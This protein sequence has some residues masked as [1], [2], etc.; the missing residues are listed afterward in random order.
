MLDFPTIQIFATIAQI[1]SAIFIYLRF[2]E[3]KH[4]RA[5]RLFA[6][7][8]LFNMLGNA[9]LLTR[10][11]APDWVSIY[12][13]NLFVGAAMTYFLFSI[14]EFFQIKMTKWPWFVLLF[15]Q[16]LLIIYFNRF[17]FNTPVRII[18]VGI[19]AALT[20]IV[21]FIYFIQTDQFKGTTIR[22]ILLVQMIMVAFAFI[23][24][25]GVAWFYI[26]Q[27]QMSV[28]DL[29]G[30]DISRILLG[31][32]GFST[33]LST[34]FLFEARSRKR[35]ERTASELADALNER[36]KVYML[37]SHELQS[38]L[39]QSLK[40]LEDS[41]NKPEYTFEKLRTEMENLQ[42]TLLEL[43]SWARLRIQEDQK[44][45]RIN[46]EV[47]LRETLF[48]YREQLKDR[49][50]HTR[51][52][53]PSSA[54][55]NLN[56]PALF[57]IA[58]RALIANALRHAEENS[59]IN[60]SVNVTA[61]ALILLIN[62]QFKSGGQGVNPGYRIGLKLLQSEIEIAGGT[63]NFPELQNEYSVILTLPLPS[64]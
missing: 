25:S 15:V 21:G 55:I 20:M 7:T 30:M 18:V 56:Q 14:L 52:H 12:A 17:H 32:F 9:L 57:S 62:N 38:P 8:F 2:R 27:P 37:I 42:N 48:L 61:S 33:G 64:K 63:L 46:I 39:S 10:G 51:L 24:R 58:S 22:T 35:T 60:I 23:M 53:L 31:V 43:L 5:L 50:L 47:A 44:A 3:E 54:E 59:V 11:T 36:D 29:P 6:L 4:D 1:T 34:L 19:H 45:G 41:E 28:S 13:A 49:R 40:L 26:D 16:L